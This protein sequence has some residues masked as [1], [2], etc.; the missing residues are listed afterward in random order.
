MEGFLNRLGRGHDVL[1]LSI[2]SR[3]VSHDQLPLFLQMKRY[4]RLTETLSAEA[5]ANEISPVI[6]K[7]LAP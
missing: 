7:H 2:V 6:K 3:D 4:L 1:L 5:I